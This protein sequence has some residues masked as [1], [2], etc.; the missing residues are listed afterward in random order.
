M[1]PLGPRYQED[2]QQAP[3]IDLEFLK[4]AL[5][6]NAQ[7]PGMPV[8]MA[9]QAPSTSQAPTQKTLTIWDAQ[10]QQPVD[11]PDPGGGLVGQAEYA[12]TSGQA[13]QRPP[14][15]PPVNPVAAAPAGRP[16]DSMLNS[17]NAGLGM[18]A[19]GGTGMPIMGTALART[20]QG[21]Q[22]GATI[23]NPQGQQGQAASQSEHQ[24][25]RDEAIARLS[26]PRSWY[27]PDPTGRTDMQVLNLRGYNQFLAGQAASDRYDTPEDRMM[28]KVNT[29]IALYDRQLAEAER[30]NGGIP[31]TND[32]AFQQALNARSAL[33]QQQQALMPKV[34]GNIPQ[35]KASETPTALDNLQAQSDTE[36]FGNALQ[37]NALSA[38]GDLF[39]S[40]DY[41]PYRREQSLLKAQELMGSPKNLTPS[42]RAAYQNRLQ[43]FLKTDPAARDALLQGQRTGVLTPLGE[44][45]KAQAT[46][47]VAYPGVQMAK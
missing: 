26:D 13:P 18:A 28:N 16:G 12:R 30:H 8:G 9:A 21:D 15:P 33:V 46:N 45:L 20:L 25:T 38:W 44:L 24:E 7:M 42:R 27:G 19:P 32:P 40:Q 41:T 34:Y 37:P 31:P 10:K 4:R 14:L 6:A 2:Q 36:A 43:D 35:P 22:R 39:R 11:I 23:M 5:A 17:M 47:P 3:S 1:T 29:G